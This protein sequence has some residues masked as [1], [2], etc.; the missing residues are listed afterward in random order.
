MVEMN[1][2]IMKI[3]PDYGDV[4]KPEVRAKY[5]YLEGWVSIVGNTVLFAVKFIIGIM[6]NSICLI[7]DSV[8]SFSDVWTS[9]VVIIGF[10][11]SKKPPDEKHPFGHGR[12]EFIAAL[13]IAVSLIIVGAEFVY[14]SVERILH[15]VPV[16]G[17]FFVVFL[18]FFFVIIKEAMTRFSVVLGKRIDSPALIADAWHH[19]T[20]AFTTVLVMIAILGNM[21]N[22]PVLDSFFGVVIAGLVIYVGINL[23][24]KSADKIIGLAPS[25][26][27]LDRVKRLAGDVEGVKGAHDVIVHDYGTF[28]VASLHLEVGDMDIKDAHT[29]ASAVEKKIKKET[30]MSTI[31]HIEPWGQVDKEKMKKIIRKIVEENKKVFS[32]HGIKISNSI[33]MHVVVDKKMNVE[34]SHK[35]SHKIESSIQKMYKKYK[36]HIHI[37]PG[38]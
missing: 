9:C 8:H 37:E 28:K 2:L 35:L 6:I 1:F 13:I 23:A 21:Y 16:K 14:Q 20:D 18:L 25:P 26:E 5:G 12:V 27:L 31:V 22:Y 15:P 17:S 38:G 24:K 30:G 7:A 32:C 34:E 11:F 29:I 4:S 10:K 3:I 19:R 36:V 33:N